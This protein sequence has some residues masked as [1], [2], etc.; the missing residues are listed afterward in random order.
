M[1]KEMGI[2]GGLTGK[3]SVTYNE[4][5]SDSAIRTPRDEDG[6]STDRVN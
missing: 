1:S 6:S 4:K 5:R 3:N 2:G